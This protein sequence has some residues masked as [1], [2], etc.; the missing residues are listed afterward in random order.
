MPTAT[1]RR[2]IPSTPDTAAIL[3]PAAELLGRVLLASLFLLSGLGK[4]A[5]YF[6]TADYMSVPEE[7]VD[8]RGLP[9]AGRA[10]RRALQSRRALGA[11]SRMRPGTFRAGRSGGTM[12]P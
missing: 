6:A 2:P 5:S 9:V 4:A 3:S 7:R 8:R 12:P 11:L 1:F 10:R